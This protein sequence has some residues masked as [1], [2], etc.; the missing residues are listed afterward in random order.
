MNGT[1]VSFESK[2]ALLLFT[3]ENIGIKKDNF[4]YSENKVIH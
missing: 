2:H 3:K 1:I 4:V